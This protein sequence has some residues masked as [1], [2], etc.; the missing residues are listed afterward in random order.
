MADVRIDAAAFDRLS[1]PAAQA[2]L[3]P[4]CASD[5]WLAALVADRPYRSLAAAQ[6]RSDEV[7]AGLDWP[8]VEQ[9]LEAHP[10]I[11]D[12][13]AGAGTE[14]GWSRQEQSTATGSVDELRAGNLDYEERFG[15]VFL[16]C[17]TGLPAERILAALR[18]RLEN[19]PEAERDVVRDELAK[20]VRLRL[21]KTLT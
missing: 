5:A 7:L 9:A 17:A 21:A 8:G 14:A 1:S 16:I 11:G 15:H 13:P 4:V 2:L 18:A 12:R 19:D 10:R 6:A 20:I 3:R